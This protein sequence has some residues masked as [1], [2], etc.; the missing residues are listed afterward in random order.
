MPLRRL[1]DDV[2]VLDSNLRPGGF[3]L[4]ARMTVLRL[5]GGLALISPLAIDDALA[6][7]LAAIAPVT[8]IVAPSLQHHK[9]LLAAKAR[10]PV[11]RVL[12]APGLRKKRPAYPIDVELTDG[13]HEL[14]AA[15]DQHLVRGMPAL[16]EIVFLHRPSRTLIATDLLFNVETR[17]WLT[18]FY[19]NRTG[20]NGRPSRT[21]LLRF[22]TKD[23]AAL[24]RT[25]DELAA[26]PF[27]RLIVAHGRVIETGGQAALRAALADL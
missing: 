27:D 16:G 5:A 15:V 20:S 9:F 12:A 22:L 19:L 1:A 11:A 7:E 25:R 14:D 8:A 13:G 17:H 23:R 4:G 2:W 24:A 26:W 18:R 6:A 10:F 3:D 21:L